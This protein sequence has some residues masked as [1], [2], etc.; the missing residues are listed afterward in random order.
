V[1]EEQLP[2]RFPS[3]EGLDCSLAKGRLAASVPPRLGERHAARRP[4]RVR[5][6]DTMDTFVAQLMVFLRF[7]PRGRQL[8]AFDPE[9]ADK[10]APVDQY[11][12]GVSTPSSH[13]LYA[14]FIT[15]VLSESRSVV[16]TPS[17][18]GHGAFRR[19]DVEE[20]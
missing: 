10:W 11:I 14:R 8:R 4:C 2:V 7:Q 3:T 9:G 16:G 13:L 20:L 18:P 6:P 17:K 1:P 19:V 15:K 12:G 5:D